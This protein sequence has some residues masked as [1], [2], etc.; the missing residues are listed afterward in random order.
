MPHVL[1][2]LHA[3]VPLHAVPVHGGAVWRPAARRRVDVHP[4]QLLRVVDG[5]RVPFPGARPWGCAQPIVWRADG[6][7]L[8]GGDCGGSVE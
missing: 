8:G 6:G 7:E 3:L 1:R 4:V 5:D 2:C